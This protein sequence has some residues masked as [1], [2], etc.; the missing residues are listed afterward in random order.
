MNDFNGDRSNIFAAK[1]LDQS[2]Y[3]K[4]CGDNEYKT[5]LEKLEVEA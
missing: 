1:I 4:F 3:V 2:S 5:N